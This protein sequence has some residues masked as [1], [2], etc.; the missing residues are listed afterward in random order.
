MKPVHIMGA[1][2][3]MALWGT[4]FA[5]SR[6]ALR[7]FSPMIMMA[8]RF[9]L[10]ALVL[11]PFVKF[12]RGQ[13]RQIF[14]YSL[15]LGGVHFP[16]MLHGMLGAEASTASIVIQLQV[17][18]ASLLAAYFFKDKL[19]WKRAIGM[20]IAFVGVAIIAL[21]GGGGESDPFHLLLIVLAAAAFS[22]SNIQVKWMGSVDPYQLNAYMALFTVP[23]LLIY[24]LFLEHGQIEQVLHASWGAWAGIAYMVIA[25]TIIAYAIWQP[26][27]RQYDVNQTVP[28][29]MLVPVFGV[30]SGVLWL[31]EAMSWALIVGGALVV[32]GVGI[33]LIRRPKIVVARNTV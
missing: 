5:V 15:V 26:M 23:Q 28:F 21:R 32:G 24:S 4:N 10:V 9:G 16:L 7:E 33:I 1:L 27:I 19:G 18:F 22:F 17:P 31:G 3:V 11:L 29:L 13:V 6:Y 8:V 14:L 20:G 12:P 25:S 30:A 2:L